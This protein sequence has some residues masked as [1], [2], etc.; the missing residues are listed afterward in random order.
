[1]ASNPSARR[2]IRVDDAATRTGI[3]PRSI[4]YVAGKL[5][6]GERRKIMGAIKELL[7]NAHEVER[8]GDWYREKGRPRK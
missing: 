4:R 1:M 6:L 2:T 7:L 8:I 3:P 5:E